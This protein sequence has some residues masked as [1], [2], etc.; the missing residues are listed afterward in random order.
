VGRRNDPPPGGGAGPR[1]GAARRRA[2]AGC[3]WGC[4]S[5]L[6]KRA[7]VRWSAEAKSPEEKGGGR[8]FSFSF[9][10]ITE[11]IIGLCEDYRGAEQLS[12][13]LENKVLISS[14]FR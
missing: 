3:F 12:I 13:I 7:G 5:P 6:S 4:A 10:Y 11:A 1:A 14:I 8:R 2:R 9:R